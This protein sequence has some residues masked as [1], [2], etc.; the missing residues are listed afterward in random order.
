MDTQTVEELRNRHPPSAPD[1]R[2]PLHPDSLNLPNTTVAPD[3]VLRAIQSFSKASSGGFDGLRPRHIRDMIAA[4]NEHTLLGALVNL[5]ERSINGSLPSFVLKFFYGASLWAFRKK[6]GGLRPI[7]CG[8]TLRRLATK[9]AIQRHKAEISSSLLPRQVGC[10]VRG[11]AEAMVHAVRAYLGKDFPNTKL[12]V[13][14]DFT[15]AFNSIRRD[16][17]LEQV[18]QHA[19]YLYKMAYQAYTEQTSLFNDDLQLSSCSG[20]QQGDPC[21]PALFCFAIK[22]LVEELQSGCTL[23]YLDPLTVKSGAPNKLF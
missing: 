1:L 21:G 6:S 20:V 18:A 17:M 12:M 5:C 23:W 22:G 2:E 8:I 3:E 4:D 15:N 16:W 11:G 9:V 14:L 10:G 7:A 19:P 13:K